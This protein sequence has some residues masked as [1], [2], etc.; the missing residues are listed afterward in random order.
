M[1]GPTGLLDM[2][3]VHATIDLSKWISDSETLLYYFI[4]PD[5]RGSFAGALC[6]MGPDRWGRDSPEWAV[7][8][9]FRTDDPARHDQAAVLGRFPPYARHPRPGH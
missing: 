2:V 6:A 7:H 8:T 1:E 4:N 9:A 3:S 5:G